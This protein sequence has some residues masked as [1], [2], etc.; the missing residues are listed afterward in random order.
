MRACA[1]EAT[2]LVAPASHARLGYE[3]VQFP[4]KEHVGLL[5]TTYLVDVPA[6]AGLS[7]GP[8]VYGAITGNRGGFFT[9]GGEIAWRRQLTGPLG[10][11]VGFFAGGGLSLIHISEPT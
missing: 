4:D 5:G 11:E 8:A 2:G 7:A 9:I 3:R 6:V 10:I 1:D